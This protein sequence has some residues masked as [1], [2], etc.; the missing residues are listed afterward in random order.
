MKVLYG[1]AVIKRVEK[2]KLPE[3]IWQDFRDAFESLAQTRNFRLFDIKKLVNKGPHAYYRLRIRDYR[4]LFRLDGHI[5]YVEEIAPRG[6]V[7][8]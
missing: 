6:G 1:K 4:A 5:I 8:Q 3:E 7:Y 2:H